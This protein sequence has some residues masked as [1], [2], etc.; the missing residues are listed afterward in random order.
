MLGQMHGVSGQA[1]G[2]NRS[3]LLTT[4][5]DVASG[6]V[7]WLN[8]SGDLKLSELRSVLNMAA[9]MQP[10]P[11]RSH[12]SKQLPSFSIVQALVQQKPF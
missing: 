6:H 2:S 4:R 1:W 12:A 11:V 8:T 10:F 9:S 3:S 7:P 5:V